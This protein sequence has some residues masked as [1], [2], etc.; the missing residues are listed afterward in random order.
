MSGPRVLAGD[1]DTHGYGLYVSKSGVDVTAADND[2]FLFDSTAAGQA[3]ALYWK[4]V[5]LTSSSTSATITYNNFGVRCYAIGT[6]SWCAGAQTATNITC[7][8][9]PTN[10][11]TARPAARYSPFG[12][13][14]P[15]GAG[16]SNGE[17]IGFS[18]NNIDNGNNTGTI[19]V[20]RLNPLSEGKDICVQ[21]LV[22]KDA[23]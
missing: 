1:H 12:G 7:I 13:N 4:E 19:T 17:T 14:I 18:I 22:F 20:A 21:V 5:T 15:T 16:G 3:Q 23:V 8:T 11:S 6:M 10:N 9:D 2:Y